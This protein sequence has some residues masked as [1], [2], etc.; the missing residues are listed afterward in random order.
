MGAVFLGRQPGLDRPVAVKV[1]RPDR[2]EAENL[3]RFRREAQVMASVE[4]PHLIRLIDHGVEEG[5]PYLVMEF[6]EGR[7][8]AHVL[9]DD[10]PLSPARAREVLLP[11]A[12]ALQAIHDAGII[13]RDV[14]PDNIMVEQSG[15]VLLMDLGLARFA[16]RGL[17]HTATGEGKIVGTIEY[18]SP[19]M[20]RGEEMTPAA[21]W[22]SWGVTT[23]ETLVGDIPF[24]RDQILEHV[25]RVDDTWLRPARPER[26][27]P[28][29]PMAAVAA[30][31]MAG[32]PAKR[33]AG[34]AHLRGA[35]E[36]TAELPRPRW[37]GDATRPLADSTV[38][39]ARR[40]VLPAP[41]DG[42]LGFALAGLGLVALSLVGGFLV[43]APGTGADLGQQ[44]V[45]V[46]DA[47]GRVAARALASGAGSA[48]VE[49]RA[50]DGGE[51][52]TQSLPVS[53]GDLPG[54]PVQP[55]FEAR[56]VQ[57][58]GDA[59]PWHAY[60]LPTLPT[61]RWVGSYPVVGGVTVVAAGDTPPAEM[62]YETRPAEGTPIRL[63][64]RERG[65]TGSFWWHQLALAGGPAWLVDPEGALRR[66]FPVDLPALASPRTLL[67]EVRRQLEKG[68]T[69]VT[70]PGLLPEHV[71][72]RAAWLALRSWA[73]AAWPE[74]ADLREPFL[75]VLETL[76][77]FEGGQ[78]H[79]SRASRFPADL[80]RVHPGRGRELGAQLIDSGVLAPGVEDLVGR[81][82]S[83]G[84][85][86]L[87]RLNGDL[88]GFDL[89]GQPDL[90]A[91][92]LDE[93]GGL[94]RSVVADGLRQAFLASP[95][96][97]N[98]PADWVAWA[99]W[100]RWLRP[101]L[102]EFATAGGAAMRQLFHEFG[103]RAAPGA[104]G[105]PFLPGRVPPPDPGEDL[106]RFEFQRAW[107]AIAEVP[108]P[109]RR[110]ALAWVMLVG[111]LPPPGQPLTEVDG[112]G[113]LTYLEVLPPTPLGAHARY[114]RERLDPA[115][116]AGWA[117]RFEALGAGL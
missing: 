110:A 108:D 61:L 76:V 83:T 79:W 32:R 25:V 89:V 111:A 73:L 13:H 86:L 60:A 102:A 21:D 116:A 2:A 33:P 51:G 48:T 42:N 35:L 58:G 17:G 19:E 1:L 115:L 45:L 47:Q 68:P 10:G 93:P 57:G 87:Q 36:G 88:Y 53:D 62:V 109:R 72:A 16:R 23:Y 107:R 5:H 15:R 14:K 75:A 101:S 112:Q 113:A 104:V 100:N 65:R 27:D 41:R 6:V 44:V 74:L 55:R 85:R 105:S 24:A 84:M 90:A 81:N 54:I 77:T 12:D 92:L 18:M 78:A 28:D 114:L 46:A 39:A 97:R 43:A 7:T 11:V 82:E 67:T 56:L 95:Y 22:Y 50:A 64:P 91:A 66:E 96:A 71:R 69:Y 26:I 8:L 49:L 29:D 94:D 4:H 38:A 34:A 40:K 37:E 103:S 80:D 70:E 30:W 31:C 9:H 99:L 106:P 3:G 52:G 20:L 117:T 98:E 63:A 59:G